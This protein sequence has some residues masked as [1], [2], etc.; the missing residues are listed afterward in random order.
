MKTVHLWLREYAE[1]HK[2]ETNKTIHWICVPAI[3]FSI[4]GLFYSIKL[5]L[6]INGIA[7]NAAMILILLVTIYYLRLTVSLGIG[8]FFFWINRFNNLLRD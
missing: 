4:S 3:F 5:P 8:M 7:V 1:S 6:M 2:N